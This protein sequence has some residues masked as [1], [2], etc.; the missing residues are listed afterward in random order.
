MSNSSNGVWKTFFGCGG[1]SLFLL[2]VMLLAVVLACSATVA[3]PIFDR[4]VL[5]EI[6]CPPGST[7]ITG[8]EE[9]TY[10]RPGERIL[11]GYCVDAQ[12]NESPAQDLGYGALEYFPRYFGISLAASLVLTL[13]VVI[14]LMIL[15]RV[16]KKK[17][18]S[19]PVPTDPAI[20]SL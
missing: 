15:Y 19:K 5:Q 3:V 16:I 6:A 20:G 13:L 11:Y 8:W 2:T 1:F 17:F 14:P 12:G 7:L 10:T 9:T 18:F 4:D